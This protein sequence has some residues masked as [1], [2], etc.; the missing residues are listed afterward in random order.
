MT[1]RLPVSI[2]PSEPSLPPILAGRAT[3][4]VQQRIHEFY[5]SVAQIFESWVA[6]R[7]SPHTQRAYREDV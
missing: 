6:R 2:P 5:S 4:E 7:P 3:L 1:T